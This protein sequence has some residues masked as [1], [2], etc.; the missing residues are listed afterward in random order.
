MICHDF[1]CLVCEESTNLC[2]GFFFS[3]AA[4]GDC[5]FVSVSPVISLVLESESEMSLATGLGFIFFERPDGNCNWYNEGV[6]AESQ[7]TDYWEFL[8]SDWAVA[9][10]LGGVGATGG[11]IFFLFS[12][13]MCCSS[14]FLAL[15]VFTAFLLLVALTLCQCMT[16]MV[17]SSDVCTENECQFSRAAGWSVG[18]AACYSLSG[19][20]H[21]LMRDYPGQGR[22]VP[23][24][25]VAQK[26]ITNKQEQPPTDEEQARSV[27]G[28]GV[29]ES[30]ESAE[31]EQSVE[32]D[33]NQIAVHDDPPEGVVEEVIVA[34]DNAGNSARDERVKPSKPLVGSITGGGDDS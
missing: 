26:S 28:N 6:D 11:F 30:D 7:I 16:F 31:N 4:L 1:R 10:A 23:I 9:R 12:L 22:H 3:L 2:L 15:R 13:L 20:C 34:D 25:P 33:D 18:A 5:S 24:K 19:F 8:G 21:V 32:A 17:F 14:C 29:I 27:E